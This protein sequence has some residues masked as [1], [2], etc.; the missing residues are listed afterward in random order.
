MLQH[1]VGLWDM[2]AVHLCGPIHAEHV[3]GSREVRDGMEDERVHHV[4]GK[5]TGTNAFQQN[6]HDS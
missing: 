2:R 5:T 4:Q 1:N 3:D 6:P